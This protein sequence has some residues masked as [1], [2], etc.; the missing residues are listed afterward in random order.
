[1]T[2][3]IESKSVRVP[4][5]MTNEKNGFVASVGSIV[6]VNH[7]NRYQEARVNRI[8]SRDIIEVVFL[9]DESETGRDVPRNELTLCEKNV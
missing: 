7:E 4:Y 3:D 9:D 1:M 2:S 5:D 6:L 8:K